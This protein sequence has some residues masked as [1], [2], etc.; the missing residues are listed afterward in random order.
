MAALLAQH[1][2]LLVAI[3]AF[4][5]WFAQSLSLTNP[6]SSPP[7]IAS[8]PNSPLGPEYEFQIALGSHSDE[9]CKR[10]CLS[11]QWSGSAGLI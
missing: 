10:R 7:F 2:D 6:S 1:P 3:P 5:A 4:L 11:A 9:L 8:R